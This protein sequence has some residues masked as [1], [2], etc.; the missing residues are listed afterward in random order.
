DFLMDRIAMALACPVVSTATCGL[1]PAWVEA[2]L[3]A[4]IARQT[5]LDQ[6]GNLP[7]V[8][9]AAGPR[10]LGAIYPP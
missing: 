6:P 7:G 10:V 5:L 8:T 2:I 4:W 3:F 9:G 1:D